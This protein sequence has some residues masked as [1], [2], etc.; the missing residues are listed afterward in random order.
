MTWLRDCV[1]CSIQRCLRQAEDAVPLLG[2]GFLLQKCKS[3]SMYW[4]SSF[5]CPFTVVSIP[6]FEV[7][8]CQLR[9]KYDHRYRFGKK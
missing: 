1:S 9:L 5:H 8:Q 2:T 7:I 4:H 3:C 6:Y